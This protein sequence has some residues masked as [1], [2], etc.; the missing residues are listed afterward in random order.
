MDVI[1]PII[2]GVVCAI[3]FGLLGF[4]LRKKV[5]EA[6]IGSAER[7]AKRIVDEAAKE[8]ENSK[9][10]AVL[11]AREQIFKERNEAERDLKEQRA[12]VT[13]QERRLVAKEENLERKMENLEK[14]NEQLSQKLQEADDLKEK[15]NEALAQHIEL[16]QKVSG[17][18]AEEAKA[19]L[20][21]KLETEVRH[22][23]ALKIIEIE[24]K[25]KEEAD[26]KAK[27]IISLAIQR[28]ASDH[29][30]ETT[31]STVALPNEEMKGRI[32]G[33]E[34]RNIRTI[35]QLTGVDLII[36]DTPEAITVSCFDPIRREV[37]RM[38]LEKLISDG[39]I[40]RALPMPLTR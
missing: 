17:Y 3:V 19:E 18:T 30:S 39:R 11:E 24:S 4:I 2:T 35:E 13:R 37:A 31:T 22:D 15:I 9:K 29:V 28:C 5:S 33:R 10:D 14:K 32:I 36:D 8:A 26:Q 16:L 1:I 23:A 6:K 40:P 25:L 34:G 27:D 12:E 38:T 20:L 21:Q 7:E